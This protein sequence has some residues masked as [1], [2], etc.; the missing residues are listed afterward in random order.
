MDRS[1]L[2]PGGQ[3]KLRANEALGLREKARMIAGAVY[4]IV[5]GP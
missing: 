5:A 3:Y 1:L 2:I 4:L